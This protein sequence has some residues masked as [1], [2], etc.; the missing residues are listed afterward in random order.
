MAKRARRKG[1]LRYGVPHDEL[2]RSMGG[3]GFSL[4]ARLLRPGP[5]SEQQPQQ[6][7]RALS[8]Q[9]LQRLRD[10]LA[11]MRAEGSKLGKLISLYV[12]RARRRGEY[13]PW[14][15]EDAARQRGLNQWYQMRYR[16]DEATPSRPHTPPGS[17]AQ[18]KVVK[19]RQP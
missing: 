10:V 12:V 7:V 11:A 4:P 2:I 15:E 19:R 17:K 9:E 3:F 16:P 1:V 13:P 18:L 8:E 5:A 14:T 6:P